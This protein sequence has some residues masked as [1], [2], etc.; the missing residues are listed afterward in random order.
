MKKIAFAALV[1]LFVPLALS[2][3]ATEGTDAERMGKDQAQQYL[4]E[5]S[6][7]KF[8]DVAFWGASMSLDDGIVMVRRFEGAPAGKK[9]MEGEEQAGIN[10]QDKFVL[11]AKMQFFRRGAGSVAIFPVRPMPIEG[12]TKTISVWVVGRNYNHVLKAVIADYFNQ[13]REVTLGKLNF[14][15]WKQLTAAV[16]PRIVQDEYHFAADRGVKLV[17]FK[18]EFDLME[19]YGSYYVYFDDARAV[20]DLFA[21]AYRDTDDMTD[22]W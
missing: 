7:S 8:E 9:P 19:R 5:V 2:A 18:I 20:S 17:G 6:V 3:Q 11:G 16:P 21:E 14:M 15:G 10:E 13:R 12:I 4:G 22:G 1:A